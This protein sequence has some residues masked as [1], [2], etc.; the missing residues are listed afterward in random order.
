[1]AT[2]GLSSSVCSPRYPRRIYPLSPRDLS[3]EQLAVVFAM[4][5]RRPEPFDQ[6]AQ[7]VTETKA[8]EFHEKWVLGYGHASVAEHAVLHFAVENISRLACDALEDNRLASY[9][10]KSSRFQVIP[11]DAFYTP[12]ELDEHPELKAEFIDACHALFQAYHQMVPA[13]VDYLKGIRPPHSG[14]RESAYALRLRREA[15][16]S[17][18]F[19]LPA[20]TLTNVGVT[21]NARTLEH[22]ITKL[23]SSDL[24]EEREIGALLK[25]QA[26]QITPTLVKYADA[27]PYLQG[28]KKLFRDWSTPARPLVEPSSTVRLVYAEPHAEEKVLTALLYERAGRPYGEVAEEVWRLST[29]ERRAVWAEVLGRLGDFDTPP[30]ALEMATVAFEFVLDYGAYRE[31]KRHRMQTFIPQPLT[32]GLGYRVPRLVVEA[33][34]GAVFR[35]AVDIA[36]KAWERVARWDPRV[37]QYLVTHAHRRRVVASMNLREAWH[38]FRLRTGPQAHFSLRE[39][40]EQALQLCQKEYPHIFGWFRQRTQ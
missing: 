15:T 30:R 23:L 33:G 16:D 6:I 27:S 5:S 36:E 18:R 32:V 40:V 29:D 17:C 24:Q 21:M 22:A 11:P 20:A 1:M 31:F 37:A 3:P 39:A 28:L 8:S 4:T 9:T 12:P 35:G 13:C 2:P 25:E 38:I 19:I 34:V 14:E 7:Q 26:R 10:E